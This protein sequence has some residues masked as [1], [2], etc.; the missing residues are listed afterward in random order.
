[1]KKLQVEQLTLVVVTTVNDLLHPMQSDFRRGHSCDYA[2][3]LRSM[4]SDW[5]INKE[6]KKPTAV[7]F[8][9]FQRAF[10][11]VNIPVK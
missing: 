3:G 11:V 8:L 9:D 10:D 2:I 7:I 1:M 6:N 4:Y 5:L